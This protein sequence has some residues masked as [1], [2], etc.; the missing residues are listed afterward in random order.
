LAFRHRLARALAGGG[1]RWRFN[2]VQVLLA[3]LTVIAV[4]GLVFFGIRE[5]LLASPDMA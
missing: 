4:A 3:L 2:S 5:S 1:R